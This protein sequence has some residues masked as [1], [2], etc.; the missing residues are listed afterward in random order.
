MAEPLDLAALEAGERLLAGVP[1]DPAYGAWAFAPW[2]E[3]PDIG[4]VTGAD[5]CHV[6]TVWRD[7]PVAMWDADEAR[8]AVWLVNH[9]A[10]LL[11]LARLGL[12]CERLAA[13]LAT[14]EVEIDAALDR[15]AMAQK[16]APKGHADG[17]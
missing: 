11:R 6:A 14:L 10:D 15:A 12:E 5:G 17:R 2:P 3:N 1:A 7:R 9:A 8:A 13:T 4:T 16:R